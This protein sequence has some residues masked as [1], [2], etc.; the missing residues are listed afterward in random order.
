[1][2]YDLVVNAFTCDA[3]KNQRLT[4]HAAGR[5]WRPLLHID[6]AV[7]A[8]RKA[9]SA[10]DEAVG[11]RVF[12]VLGDNHQILEVALAVRNSLR[13]LVRSEIVLD[14]QP[15]GASRSYRAS[16]DRFREAVGFAPAQTITSAVS[17]MWAMLASRADPNNAIYYNVQWIRAL[18]DTGGGCGATDN[19]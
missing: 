12:N 5:M 18:L 1:M 15:I 19:T 11:G 4:V 9:L 8:Y 17:D 7:L 2:R 10:S 14:L 3:F 6:E 16:G 13:D